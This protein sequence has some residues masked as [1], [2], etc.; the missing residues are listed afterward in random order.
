MTVGQ[1]VTG[2]IS[3]DVC[4]VLARLA[5]SVTEAAGMPVENA[6]VW[7]VDEPELTPPESTRARRLGATDAS[8]TLASWHCF[9]GF[10]DVLFWQR[11]TH[12]TRLVLLILHDV[13]GVRRAI[14]EPPIAEV[15]RDGDLRGSSTAG[16]RYDLP[17]AVT[18]R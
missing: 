3:D 14:V 13:H 9:A 8:G 11:E 2:T 15:F 18:F 7:L 6:E 12:P 17:I 1:V 16:R 4:V 5:F 10:D